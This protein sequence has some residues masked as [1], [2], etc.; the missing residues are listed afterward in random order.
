MTICPLCNIKEHDNETIHVE[1]DEFYILDTKDKK[2]H[3]FR[4]MICFKWH[5][6]VPYGYKDYLFDYFLD[7]LYNHAPC[8]TVCVLEDVMSNIPGHFHVVASDWAGDDIDQMHRTPHV[9]IETKV[10]EERRLNN[11]QHLSCLT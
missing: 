8:D 3:E 9:C 6:I 10:G 11:P 4:V 2:G 5:D 7:W 1:G